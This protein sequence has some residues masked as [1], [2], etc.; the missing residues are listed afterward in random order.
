MVGNIMSPRVACKA[1]LDTLNDGLEGGKIE[2]MVH[3]V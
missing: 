1:R 2:H 3:R